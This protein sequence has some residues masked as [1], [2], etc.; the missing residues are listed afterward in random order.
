L[1]AGVP[2]A[3]ALAGDVEFAGD[4]GPG[5]ALG[6]QLGSTFRRA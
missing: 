6:E 2:A 3:G 4:L 5:A 1:P